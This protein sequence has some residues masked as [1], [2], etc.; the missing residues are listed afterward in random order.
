MT[1]SDI[2]KHELEL[3]KIDLIKKHDELGMRASGK[4]AESIEVNVKG[5]SGTI[6]GNKYTEQLQNGREGGKYPPVKE[7]ERWL[8]EKGITPLEEKMKLS[9]LA[10]LIAR[11]IAQDG[12]K[13]YQ[14][15]GTD[16][17][18]S[19]ITPERIQRIIDQV[20]EFHVNSFVSEVK[21]IFEKMAA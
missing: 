1:P 13:Y 10:F 6:S 2:L 8:Y 14:Q 5:T 7:I 16:L 17:I 12:T 18:D 11:K 3:I 15:G 19:V 21:G 4:W 20:S 9:T